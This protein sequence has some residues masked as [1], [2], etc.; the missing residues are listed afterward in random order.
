MRMTSDVLGGLLRPL[1]AKPKTR[2]PTS[3]E[4]AA[5]NRLRVLQ[6]VAEHGHLRCADLACCWPGARYGGQMAQ[7]TV[8]ALVATGEL[9]ARRNAHGG[10]SYVLTRVGAGVLEVRGIAARH[11]LDLARQD[12][13]T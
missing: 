3:R 6:A 2:Q 9:M 8:R 7:R 4:R 12:G 11:G 1:A 5:A 10:L 13:L